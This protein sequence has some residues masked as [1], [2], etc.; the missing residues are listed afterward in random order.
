[1]NY[2]FTSIKFTTE[3]DV[4]VV[5][6]NRPGKRNALNDTLVKELNEVF[7]HVNKNQII[8]A[9]I[10]T[11]AGEAFCSGADLEYLKNISQYSVEE[12]Q[13]DSKRL[14]KMYQSIYE[15]RKPVIAMV[16]GPAL[17]GGC[18][19]ATV[20]DFIIASEEHAKFGYPE[21]KIGFIPAIVLIFLIKRIGDG[22]ARELV[23]SGNIISTA[24]AKNIGLI[25]Q[26][27]KGE[28]LREFTNLF[29]RDLIEKNSGTAMGLCKEMF[30]SFGNMDTKQS[31]EYA[32]NLNAFA[33]MTDECK[34]GIN[35]FLTKEKIKWNEP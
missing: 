17:A 29:V 27:T 9:V 14:M 28:N 22:R 18:G 7:T 5:E 11:G 3:T 35:S 1:M 2:H 15:C 16:N 25:N 24:E 19:L 31:L 34:K 30:A 6:I 23:L 13:E 26:V 33:R 4:A 32:A 21:V 10:L 8:R 12:N 20:C